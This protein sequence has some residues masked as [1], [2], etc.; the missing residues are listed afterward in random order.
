MIAIV[1]VNWNGWRDSV[2]C[3]RSCLTLID[4]PFRILICDNASADGSADLI[5]AWA[6]GELNID[7]DPHS[8]LEMPSPRLPYSVS[9]MGRG[10]AERGNDGGGAELL[11]IDTGSNLG[12]AGGN[13]I[14]LRWA[15]ARGASHAWLLNNDTEVPPDAL[16]QLVEYQKQHPGYGLIGSLMVQFYAPDQLQGYGG[17]ANP[18]TFSCRHLAPGLP[19]A[20][21][22]ER[23]IQDLLKSHE[24]FYPIGASMLVSR[25]F[26]KSVGL[27]NESY[28]LYYEELDWV[29]RAQGRF[30]VGVAFKSRVFHKVGSS[31]G[32]TPEGASRLAVG[33]LYRS[34]LIC[35]RRFARSTYFCVVANVCWDLA[36]A[37]LRRRFSKAHGIFDALSGRVEVPSAEKGLPSVALPTR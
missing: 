23:K 33:F 31:A 20:N 6:R 13:N 36:C 15:L 28:F 37:I 1:L 10:D 22:S 30:G 17:A 4:V 18:F 12:F 8:P 21:A 7:L 16:V 24:V 3:V 29:L 32:S 19:V 26:L 27:M 2:A 11:I 25:A 5:E 35:A 14:G 9:R 34:R